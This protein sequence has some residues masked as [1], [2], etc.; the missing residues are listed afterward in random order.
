MPAGQRRQESGLAV[1]ERGGQ[2]PAASRPA[3][4]GRPS[5]TS[6]AG[7]RAAAIIPFYQQIPGSTG[8][9]RGNQDFEHDAPSQLGDERFPFSLLRS[10]RGL[11][12]PTFFPGATATVATA[13]GAGQRCGGC[14]RPGA[15]KRIVP[16][17]PAS[18]RRGRGCVPARRKA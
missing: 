4:C 8:V 5:P 18:V 6:P 12:F 7:E 9:A 14:P 17:T 3:G 13:P 11:P 15:K 10:R 2:T 1:R 16:S